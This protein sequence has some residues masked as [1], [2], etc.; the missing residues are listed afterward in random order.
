M[1]YS[2]VRTPAVAQ[3]VTRTHGHNSCI[4]TMKPD[5]VS[6]VDVIELPL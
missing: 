2:F 4:V 6:W 1:V 3:K 5:A